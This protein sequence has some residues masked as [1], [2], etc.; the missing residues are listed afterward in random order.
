MLKWLFLNVEEFFYLCTPFS[1]HYVMLIFLFL[2]IFYVWDVGFRAPWDLSKKEI[3]FFLQ[4][5]L[6]LFFCNVFL[7]LSIGFFAMMQTNSLLF[8][9]IN[10]YP[11]ML[12]I[13]IFLFQ[14]FF[15]YFLKSKKKNFIIGILMG[16]NF[17]HA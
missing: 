12:S 16:A 5:S 1:M 14:M 8:F 2:F 7:T 10:P 6:T 15:L 17:R 13:I 3:V 4:M 11:P 9:L